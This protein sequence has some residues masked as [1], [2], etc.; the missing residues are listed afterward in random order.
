MENALIASA[1]L[2]ISLGNPPG[3]NSSLGDAVNWETLLNKI[4]DGEDLY[5]ISD[6]KDFRSAIDGTQFS[7]FLTAEWTQKKHSSLHYYNKLS[8]FFAEYYPNIKLATEK[9]VE[10][11]INELV[12]SDSFATTHSVIAKFGQYTEFT[13]DQVNRIV[14]AI[15]SNNQVYWIIKDEDVNQFARQVTKN[16]V[17]AI[18]LENFGLLELL[19][20]GESDEEPDSL[21]HEDENIPF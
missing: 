17:K 4:P 7:Q 8:A 12:A 1:Q 3:K 16:R 2:R 5:F 10:R 13:D 15:V 18:E 19:L 9:E 21:T 6:D 11:L 20:E 14:A